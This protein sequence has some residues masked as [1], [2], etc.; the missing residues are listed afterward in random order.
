VK[1]RL[2]PIRQKNNNHTNNKKLSKNVYYNRSKKV[3]ISNSPEK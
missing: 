2:Q 1:R 3:G